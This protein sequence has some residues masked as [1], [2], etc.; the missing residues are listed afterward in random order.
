MLEVLTY[1]SV[2][3]VIMRLFNTRGGTP[4]SDISE[5]SSIATSN[6]DHPPHAPTFDLF[7]ARASALIE[8]LACVGAA[9]STTPTVWIAATLT[10][11]F[12]S[13]FGPSV[14]A[15]ALELHQ[16]A[17]EE[18]ALSELEEPL[19]GGE[20]DHPPQPSTSTPSSVAS[21]AVKPTSSSVGEIYGAMSVVQ[22]LGSQI[23]GP[24]IY[25]WTFVA[26][27]QTQPRAIFWLSAGM[28][29]VAFIGVML[30]RLID[31]R[32][33]DTER[34]AGGRR[35]ERAPLL[36]SEEETGTGGLFG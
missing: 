24:Q 34:G 9:L 8:A 3:K 19:D 27:L 17:K 15:L 18:E 23:L 22:A 35:D 31:P 25:G 33:R 12:G 36:V 4:A 11:S 14:Q 26:T 2:D 32:A 6:L 29:G 30:I 21:T 10:A 13:G 7:V 5:T 1:T 16:E 28:I 20:V